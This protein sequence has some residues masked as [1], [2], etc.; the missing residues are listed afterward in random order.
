M[1]GHRGEGE[2][3][4]RGGG[5]VA[6]RQCVGLRRAAAVRQRCTGPIAGPADPRLP[7]LL[8]LPARPAR[9]RWFQSKFEGVVLNKAHAS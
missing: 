7:G 2:R 3:G 4:V 5:G 8:P 6:G 9:H 1:S